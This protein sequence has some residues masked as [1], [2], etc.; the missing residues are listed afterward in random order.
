MTSKSVVALENHGLKPKFTVLTITFDVY[1]DVFVAIEAK[2]EEAIWTG[3]AAYGW[4][5]SVLP[6]YF[7]SNHL[8]SSKI[9]GSTSTHKVGRSICA[10][11]KLCVPAQQSFDQTGPL[12]V[13]TYRC[14]SAGN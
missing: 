2:K 12:V 13:P 5:G 7:E 10:D 6:R 9:Q 11:Q 3:N 1:M 8:I 14:H 4:H